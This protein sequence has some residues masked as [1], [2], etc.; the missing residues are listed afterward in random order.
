MIVQTA[1]TNCVWTPP[2]PL[3]KNLLWLKYSSSFIFMLTGSLGWKGGILF[4]NCRSVCPSVDQVLFTQYL[5][6]P[7]IDQYPTWYRGCPQWVDVSGHMFKG[8][9]Q[10]TLEPS[11][12]IVHF[13]YFNPFAYLLQTGSASTEKINL[14]FAPRGTYMFLKHFL[15][16]WI[17]LHIS[18]MFVHIHLYKCF[19]LLKTKTKTKKPSTSNFC[20]F[21]VCLSSLYICLH[22]FLMLT[23][24]DSEWSACCSLYICLHVFLILTPVDSEWSACCSRLK[25]KNVT[26]WMWVL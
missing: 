15:F 17:T 20:I 6:T 2:S 10:T 19:I 11:V 8:Q 26:R 9:G 14:N 4:C 5:L 3:K 7:S 24:V 22:A 1:G 16:I 21:L 25:R 18:S 13:I 12:L 23:P